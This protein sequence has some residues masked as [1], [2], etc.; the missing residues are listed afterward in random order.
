[1]ESCCKH[2]VISTIRFLF[3]LFLWKK[4]VYDFCCSFYFLKSKNRA[5]FCVPRGSRSPR[6][7]LRGILCCLSGRME[8][9]SWMCWFQLSLLKNYLYSDLATNKQNVCTEVLSA[10]DLL[11]LLKF[12]WVQWDVCSQGFSLTFRWCELLSSRWVLPLLQFCCFLWQV[13]NRH[14]PVLPTA[15][16]GLV[17]SPNSWDLSHESFSKC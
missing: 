14:S 2:G 16:E 10:L 9:L 17:I 7:I 11:S 12:L 5:E 3:S 1:M 13:H 6:G 8:S 4:K 15:Q